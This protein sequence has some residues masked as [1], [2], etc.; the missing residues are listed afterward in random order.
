MGDGAT[1]LGTILER[2]ALIDSNLGDVRYQFA[3][4]ADVLN[5]SCALSREAEAACPDDRC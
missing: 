2:V 1:K 3:G 4:G 5:H